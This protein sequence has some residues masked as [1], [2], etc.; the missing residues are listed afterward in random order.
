MSSSVI[1]REGTCWKTADVS[2]SAVLVDADAYYS[3][4]CRAA[5]LAKR[6]I[7]LTGWQFDTKARLLRPGPDTALW[8]PIELLPFLNHLCERTPAL[9]IFITAW[10]YS[11]VYALEREWMQKLKF[12]FQ[13]HPRLHFEFLNHPEGGGCH[14]QKLVVVDG[15]VAFVG[16]LDLCDSRW[17][18]REHPAHDPRRMDVNDEPYKAFHDIQV[19]LRGPVVSALMELFSEGWRR[20]Q[21][22]VTLPHQA[23]GATRQDDPFEL[24][25]LSQGLGVPIRA[26]R[27]ALSRTELVEVGQPPIIEIQTLLEQA[28]LNAERLIYV[29]NQYFT[30]RAVAE[31]L[32]RRLAD[33]TRSKLE[34]VL[35]MP[36]GADTP[37]EDF[38]LGNRQRAIRQLVAQVAKQHGHELRLLMSSDATQEDP[39]PATF[40]HAKVLIVDDEFLTIG[41]ANLTNRSMR[42]DRELNVSYEARLESLEDGERL[43]ADIR[44]L[45]ASLL[46]EHAGFADG[47]HFL[48]LEGLVERLDEVCNDPASKLRCQELAAPDGDDD[49]LLIAIF[50]PSA[51]LDW[52]NIDSTI[53]AAFDSNDGLIRR[54]AQKVGQRLGVI[55][56]E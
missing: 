46:A 1:C 36:N 21:G 17:D 25:S 10:D 19:A 14:H 31:V 18:T 9:E 12:A 54:G 4:F 26:R 6:Y 38:V 52:S 40:I 23:E 53:E 24:H 49:P 27:A 51:P 41:S 32:C 7:Y 8:H 37:K 3:T 33:P 5:L 39:T 50:D 15:H 47:E 11:L 44:A 16:G 13:S 35:V 20:A 2:E 55:D 29:E 43:R 45:R 48:E 56:I 34:L 30:S 22:P 28:I 42:V